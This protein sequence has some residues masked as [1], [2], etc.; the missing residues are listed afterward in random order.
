MLHNLAGLCTRS[1]VLFPFVNIVVTFKSRYCFSWQI[2]TALAKLQVLS[3]FL[4]KQQG[5]KKLKLTIFPLANNL[6]HLLNWS[7]PSLKRWIKVNFSKTI[8]GLNFR[9]KTINFQLWDFSAKLLKTSILTF[10]SIQIV[11]IWF[12]FFN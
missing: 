7:N 1:Y 2:C 4:I 5:D 11:L 8:Q 9:E 12:H 10:A 3:L 6:L